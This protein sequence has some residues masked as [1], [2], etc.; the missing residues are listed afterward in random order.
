M[1]KII[2]RMMSAIL[3]V[4]LFANPLRAQGMAVDP[5]TCLGCHG[6]KISAA[7]FTASISHIQILSGL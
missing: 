5:A 6:D 3:L 1:L 7:A 4:L 2:P